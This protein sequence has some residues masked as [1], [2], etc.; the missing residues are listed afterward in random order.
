MRLPLQIT[1]IAMAALTSVA[2]VGA[3]AFAEGPAEKGVFGV[4]LIV[5]EPTGLCGKYYVGDDTA[6]DFAIGGAI[7]GR[8]LQVHGDFLW[9]P[10]ILEQKASFVLPVYLGV[11]LRILDHDGGGGDDDHVRIG[12][13]GPVG[14]LFDFTNVPLDVFAEIAAVLDYRTK[15]D[16]FGLGI[17]GG[18]GARYYF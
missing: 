14:I 17:N 13:R 18:L 2:I 15:G 7:V 11:G 1:V 6:L 12:V 9:H 3:P 4:G 10:W 5:G 16:P 8:G